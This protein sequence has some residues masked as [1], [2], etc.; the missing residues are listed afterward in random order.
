[1]PLP[2]K[3]RKVGTIEYIIKK[4]KGSDSY[5][6]MKMDNESFGS[7]DHMMAKQ[8]PDCD[9]SDGMRMCVD[10]MMNAVRSN[11][12]QSFQKGLKNF[13]KL[14]MD[15]EEQEDEFQEDAKMNT[16]GGE[17]GY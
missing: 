8:G 14:V 1:M 2:L 4:M 5:D 16:I 15:A 12:A 17:E 11:D 3:N 13:V 9:H 6:K 10:E 7:T